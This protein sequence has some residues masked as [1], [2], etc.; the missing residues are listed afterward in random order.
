M[1]Q[2]PEIRLTAY[3]R[4]EAISFLQEHGCVIRSQLCGDLVIFPSGSRQERLTKTSKW[5][6]NIV[7]PDKTIIT[8]VDG[9]SHALLLLIDPFCSCHATHL[10]H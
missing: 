7:L 3:V 8:V 6:N 4:P 5:C 2:E 9:Y 10:T 1:E